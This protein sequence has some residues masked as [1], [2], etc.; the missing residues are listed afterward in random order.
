MALPTVVMSCVLPILH[1]AGVLFL[2]EIRHYVNIFE[3]I[4][5]DT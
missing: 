1:E 4:G 5:L 3:Y 2:C